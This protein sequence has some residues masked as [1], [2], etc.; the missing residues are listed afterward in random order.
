MYIHFVLHGLPMAR[1]WRDSPCPT[2]TLSVVSSRSFLV[3]L[4]D[5]AV[6][7]GLCL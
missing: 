6:A 4:F 3:V 5:K 7:V 1:I 2:L